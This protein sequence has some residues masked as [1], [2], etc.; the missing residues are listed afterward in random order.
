MSVS[1]TDQCITH[2]VYTWP[3]YRGDFPGR[4][5]C[6]VRPWYYAT[7]NTATSVSLGLT[8]TY[9][10]E[11]KQEWRI[12]PRSK[13]KG[14]RPEFTM[15]PLS[16]GQ[17]VTK[18]Y[19][20]KI[21][22]GINGKYRW[23]QTGVV[24]KS[25]GSCAARVLTTWADG[26]NYCL[27]DE[28]SL[29][30]S[31]LSTYTESVFDEAEILKAHETCKAA[32]IAASNSSYDLLTELVEMREL[33]SMAS[34]ILSRVIDLTRKFTSAHPERVLRAA[35]HMSPRRLLR[36]S[37]K[38][39]RKLGG[40]WMTYRYGIMPL[41][42]SFNDI[43]KTL[44]AGQKI[45]SKAAQN[46][47]PRLTGTLLPDPTTSYRVVR[48]EGTVKVRGCVFSYF[49]SDQVA[50]M[51]SVGFNPLVTAWELIPYSFVVDWFIN[52][53]EYIQANFTASHATKKL[54][55]ISRRTQT[56]I[57]EYEHVGDKSF[58]LTFANVSN[59]TGWVGSAPPVQPSMSFSH[60]PSDQLLKVTETDSYDRVLIDPGYAPLVFH[61]TL[62]WKRLTDSLVMST[63]QLSRLIRAFR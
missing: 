56:R 14:S 55:C 8:H 63:N 48:A 35:V 1:Y 23:F 3:T 9:E 30:T 36:S 50:K 46:I 45:T 61:P 18:R 13:R 52:V 57:L 2:P 25:S 49:S 53:G 60:P 38:E 11:E 34:G 7:T 5:G 20:L 21:P 16:V 15:T 58:T 44:D 24:D 37:F 47:T 10:P 42:Y 19:L 33:P 4:D 59:A 22:K 29:G 6:P 26:P 51:S 27:Y 31:N 17:I 40:D 62:N 32:V 41:V 43:K 54:A 28:Q 39:F 12:K